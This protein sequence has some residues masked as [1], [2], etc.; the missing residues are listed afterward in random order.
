MH[1]VLFISADQ[2]RGECLSAAGHS[3]VKTPHLDSLAADG[4]MFM[5]HYTSSAPCGPSRATMLT[6]LYPFNHRAIANGTPLA[7][8]HTNLAMEAKRAGLETMLFGYTDTT[9]DPSQLPPQ[10][11]DF[12]HYQNVLNGFRSPSIWRDDVQEDWVAALARRGYEIPTPPSHIY[13]H[14]NSPAVMERFSREAARYSAKDSDTAYAAEQ[15]LDYLKIAGTRDWLVHLVFLRPH[16]PIIAPAPYNKMYKAAPP[17]IRRDKL[18]DES[19]QHPFLSHWLKRQSN[20]AYFQSQIN[21]RDAPLEDINSIRAVY[22]GLISEVDAHIGRIISHL[23]KTGE[24]DNTLIIFT[25]DHG[26]MLGDHWCWGKGGYFDA[27]YHLPLIIRDPRAKKRSIK[28]SRFTESIDLMPTILEWL[29]LTPPHTLDGANLLPL[30]RGDSPPPRWRDGVFW[31]YDFRSVD[32]PDFEIALSLAPDQCALNVWRDD[33][34]KY[35]HFNGMPPL[36]FDLKKDPNEFKN[37]AGDSS[38]QSVVAHYAGK[39]LNLRMT[40]AERT[41]TNYRITPRGIVRY[42][43]PRVIGGHP[44]PP[45]QSDG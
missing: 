24:Y 26:E 13:R 25:A 12:H 7:A 22:Y 6:G 35:A 18:A 4:A 1:K 20:P 43:G 9:A 32:A 17:P 3:V 23:K 37:I 33:N 30:L 45:P 10:S 40:H 5:R 41:Y 27:S 15:A 28:I 16:P 44:P 42:T 34:Y 21:V 38:M 29:N 8:R 11:P 14:L 2:W 31:E 39:I 19:A 36:L